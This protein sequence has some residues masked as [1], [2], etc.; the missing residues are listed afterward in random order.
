[1]P[2]DEGFPIRKC[3]DAC[4]LPGADVFT[5][6]CR[7]SSLYSFYS[8]LYSPSIDPSIIHLIV[9]YFSS[10]KPSVH[11][12]PSKYSARPAAYTAQKRKSKRQNKEMETAV[13]T[14]PLGSY[15]QFYDPW[16]VDDRF[17]PATAAAA[18]MKKPGTAMSGLVF[19]LPFIHPS[20]HLYKPS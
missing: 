18:T 8:S 12:S 16:A 2:E 1:M 14:E 6:T 11:P 15:A 17:S 13:Y 4:I 9:A 10:H 5:I 3:L 20:I 7:L 19:L